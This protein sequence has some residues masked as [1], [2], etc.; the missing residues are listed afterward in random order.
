MAYMSNSANRIWLESAKEN[1][2]QSL[3]ENNWHFCESLIADMKDA[4]FPL[5]A[6]T[7]QV[8]L[9]IKKAEK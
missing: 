5:E 1:F 8:E 2:D 3:I 9:N 6:E 7:C 4:G